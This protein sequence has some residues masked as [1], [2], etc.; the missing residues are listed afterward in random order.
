[1]DYHTWYVDHHRAEI[2]YVLNSKEEDMNKGYMSEALLKEVIALLDLMK[3]N[4]HRIE[5]FV[6]LNQ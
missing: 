2:G 1:M 6:G 5:A 4:L 3:M